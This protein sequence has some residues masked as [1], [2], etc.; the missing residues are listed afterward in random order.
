[1][2]KN[3]FKRGK[4]EEVATNVVADGSITSAPHPDPNVTADEKGAAEVQPEGLAPTRTTATEDIVYP[5]GLKLALLMTSV[6]VSMFLV[7]LV[8]FNFPIR[9]VQKPLCRTDLRPR[10]D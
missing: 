1:M 2:V 7:A 6:F 10:I 8:R 9:P 5:S 4:E 3:F